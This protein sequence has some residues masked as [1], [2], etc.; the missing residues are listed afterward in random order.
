[1]FAFLPVAFSI[2]APTSARISACVFEDSLGYH[3]TLIGLVFFCSCVAVDAVVV[4]AVVV[5]AVV[6]GAVVVDAVVADAV[7]VDAAVADAVVV[8][9]AVAVVVSVFFSVVIT[10]LS[11]VGVLFADEVELQ[12]VIPVIITAVSRVAAMIFKTVCLCIFFT[13]SFLLYCSRHFMPLIQ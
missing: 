4:G 11:L 12:P 7:V 10:W 9:A 1:M 5:D 8:D 13:L 3:T 6:V 2:S